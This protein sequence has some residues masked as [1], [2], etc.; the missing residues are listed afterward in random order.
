M[1]FVH[2]EIFHGE[3]TNDE[4]HRV[5]EVVKEHHLNVVIGLGGGKSIGTA[6]AIA[7]DSNCPCND[8][9]NGASTDA[10]TSALSIYL[11]S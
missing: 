8:F 7:D 6:K 1:R 10:P 3:T 4:V 11:L 2:R 9:T 5:A